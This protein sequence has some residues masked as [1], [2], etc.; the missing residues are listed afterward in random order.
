VDAL[1]LAYLTLT[2]TRGLGPR[3]IKTL[4]DSLGTASAIL[5]ASQAALLECEGIG[6]TTWRA[7]VEAKASPW[8]QAELA[9]AQKLGVTLV[10]LEHPAYP[11]ALR[12]IYDPPSLL[13]VRGR[14]PELSGATPASIGVVG[15]RNAS[16]Y[17]RH[18]TQGLAH[19]LA[20]AGVTIISGLALGIDAAAHQGALAAEG[21]QT[22]AVLG[23]GVDVI[24]PH[25]NRAL[26]AQIIAERGAVISEYPLG[27]KPLASNFPGRNRI[28]SGL[29]SGVVVVE[30]AQR[31]GALITAD[32]ALQEGRTVFAVPGR[33]ADRRAEGNLGLLKQGAV[34]IT[35]AQDILTE[36][37]WH[38]QDSRQTGARRPALEPDEAALY[39]LIERLESPLLDELVAATGGSAASLLPRLTL[40]ELKGVIQVDAGGR[41]QVRTTV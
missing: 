26:A 28:I 3:R 23:S 35:S 31:S 12:S 20:A 34:L 8:P 21:G 22:I 29:S 17:A 27:A 9:R 16:D 30:A 24:Y 7:L 4:V 13:Y 40:L 19:D 2:H 18:F 15:T 6:A 25:Q 38:H 32:Y 1:T 36:L 33:A 5:E 14:L 10:H 11:V 39:A 37:N 41:W